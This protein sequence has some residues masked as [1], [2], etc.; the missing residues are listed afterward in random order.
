MTSNTKEYN[1]KYYQQNKEKLKNYY[2]K[3]YKE[4]KNTKKEYTKK[5]L[6]NGGKEYNKKYREK[7][8]EKLIRQ[9][10]KWLKTE[11]GVALLKRQKAKLKN[12]TFEDRF[13]QKVLKTENCW[14]WTGSKI[15]KGYGKFQTVISKNKYKQEYSHRISYE[16]FVGKI[17]NKCVLHTCDNPSCVNPKHL[18]LGTQ[19]ENIEDRQQKGRTRNKYTK[20]QNI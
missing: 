2:K 9:K 15:P 13:L 11:K 12:I 14:L 18:F 20:L 8:K 5:W 4:N 7:N 16:L 3:W 17:E 19:K 1:T 6:E 10:K